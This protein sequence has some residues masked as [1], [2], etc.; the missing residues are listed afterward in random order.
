MFA[1][2]TVTVKDDG[3]GDSNIVS[4]SSALQIEFVIKN[5]NGVGVSLT[6]TALRM[7]GY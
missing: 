1:Y 3:P 4:D 7:A 5:G 6:M 2:R